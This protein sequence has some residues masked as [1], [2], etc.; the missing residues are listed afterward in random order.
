MI[1]CKDVSMIIDAKTLIIRE[2][3]ARVPRC[4]THNA[5]MIPC[6]AI[7]RQISNIII[8]M[9]GRVGTNLTNRDVIMLRS[10]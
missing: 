2:S 4:I 5:A 10:V 6:S 3:L 7:K 9:W 8:P 1:G